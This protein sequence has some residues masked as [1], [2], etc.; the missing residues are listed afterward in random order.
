MAGTCYSVRYW[1]WPDH[2][3]STVAES[4]MSLWKLTNHC[5]FLFVNKRDDG[6]VPPAVHSSL[7]EDIVDRR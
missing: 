6:S 4:L 5:Y 1:L 3:L 7:N 2:S